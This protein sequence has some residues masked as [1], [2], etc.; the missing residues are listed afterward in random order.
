MGKPIRGNTRLLQQLARRGYLRLFHH[1][2][3]HTPGGFGISLSVV[4]VKLV[5]DMRRQCVELVVWQFRPDAPGK[6]TGTHI[7]KLWPGQ[8]EM[9]QRLA[10]MSDVKMGVVGDYKVG[11]GQPGQ[12][13][14]RNGWEFRGI[15]NIQM[16]QVVNFN[17]VVTK[18]SVRFWWPHQP[19]R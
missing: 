4:V 15:Q 9:I 19:V 5:A 1:R 12:K 14:R 2:Q 18:P 8:P 7:I 13:F 6:L 17:E 11:A 3:Q 10:Q 16:R